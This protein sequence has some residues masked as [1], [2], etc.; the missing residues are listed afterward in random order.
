VDVQLAADLAD[1]AAE[2]L[3]AFSEP[4]IY[5]P[6]TGSPRTVAVLV[7]RNP[8]EELPEAQG[9]RIERVQVTALND[10]LVG[11]VPA[12]LDTGGDTVTVAPRVGGTARPMNLTKIVR[13]SQWLVT[14]EL[15]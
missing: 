3:D 6:R 15:R 14:V 11:L 13:Q 1:D 5:T 4:V 7:D 2:F 8:P 10:V 9:L 12:S